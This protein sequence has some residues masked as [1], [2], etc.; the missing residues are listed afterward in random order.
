MGKHNGRVRKTGLAVGKSL[1]NISRERRRNS[2]PNGVEDSD[3][4]MQQQSILDQDDL[5]HMMTMAELAGRDFAAERQKVVILDSQLASY[6]H[7]STTPSNDDE[8]EIKLAQQRCKKF[9]RI[10]RRPQWTNS[11]ISSVSELDQIEKSAFLKWRRELAQI[12]EQ[13]TGVLLTPYEKNLEVW[14]QLWRVLERSQII[15]QVVD[16]RNPLLYWSEDLVQY[17]REL[18]KES[19]ML[20]N[21]ADLLNE[22]LRRSW[23][24]YFLQQGLQFAFWSAKTA[25]EQ[26]NESQTSIDDP[27]HIHSIDEVLDLFTKLI[28]KSENQKCEIKISNNEKSEIKNHE[29][30][31]SEI[32]KSVTVGLVGYPNVGK[33]STINALYGRKKTPVAST[34]GRTKHFQTLII[35]DRLHL[36]DCPGLVFPKFANSK[37]EM[38]AAGVIPI[39]RLVDIISPVLLILRKIGITRF[40]KFYGLN[41]S[42]VIEKSEKGAV[43]VIS[44]LALSR[45]WTQASGRPDQ[46]RAGRMIIKDYIN[47][48]LLHCECPPGAISST[49]DTSIKDDFE[50]EESM[51]TMGPED[52]DL[53]RELANEEEE[54][55]IRRKPRRAEY[56][57]QKKQPRRKGNRGRQ[58]NNDAPA[59]SSAYIKGNRG[60]LANGLFGK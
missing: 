21:K 1:E 28:E 8:E 3:P 50:I 17:G 60:T 2:R 26:S 29:I 25:T 23:A 14:R 41:Y 19:F 20:L 10:P 48:K 53:L 13:E 32:R 12:T 4:S 35:N 56:K 54:V 27:I 15:V 47:G 59:T 46:T 7:K 6:H 58:Y 49:H 39:D 40:G 36:C 22:K 18:N 52:D 24:E 42:K 38:V 16:A 37:A 44:L 51:M 30:E 34:P 31:K 9:V 55:E 11:N 43:E 57:F 33:S 45:G 5:D